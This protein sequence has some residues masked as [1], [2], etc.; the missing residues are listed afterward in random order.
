MLPRVGDCTSNIEPNV[1]TD[2]LDA[3]YQGNWKGDKGAMRCNTSVGSVPV[4]SSWVQ[5]PMD[6]TSDA[7]EVIVNIGTV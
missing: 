3:F 5:S 2:G 1:T 6:E 7:Y 4:S